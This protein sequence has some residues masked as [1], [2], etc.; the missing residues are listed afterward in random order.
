MEIGKIFSYDSTKGSGIVILENG[1][2]VEFNL[3]NWANPNILPELGQLISWIDKKINVIDLDE[4][5]K[6]ISEKRAK[7]IVEKIDT[8]ESLKQEIE[9]I[10]LLFENPNKNII[11]ELQKYYTANE[12][13][14]LNSKENDES[15]FIMMEKITNNSIEKIQYQS[16]YNS[17]IKYTSNDGDITIVKLSEIINEVIQ[18]VANIELDKPIE[19]STIKS[20]PKQ[21][22]VK[23]DEVKNVKNDV[24]TLGI[25]SL[26]VGILGF[27]FLGIVLGP[28]SL[29]IGLNA[30]KPR[31]TFAVAGIVVGSILTII[32]VVGGLIIGAATVGVLLSN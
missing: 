17:F 3:N 4:K 25:V 26:V 13:T 1:S 2:Q 10:V 29:I 27:F 31:S 20:E 23:S 32:T 15:Y 21:D 9:K 6:I 18:A 16:S 28:I 7:E 22:T 19:I 24:D 30:P 14:L 11:K 8:D 12:Y 5:E